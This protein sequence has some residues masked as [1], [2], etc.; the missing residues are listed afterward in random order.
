[1]GLMTTFAVACSHV[2]AVW[3]V[4][5]GT[6]WNF[7]V[8][9]VAEAACKSRVLAFDLFQLDNLLC[10]AGKALVS[11]VIGKLDD[12]RCMRIVM[13][14]QATG[15]IVVRFA[16]MTLATDRNNLFDGWRVAC[17]TILTANLGF[18]SAAI[19]GNSF[20]RCRVAFDAISITE[21]RLW[22]GR[23]GAQHGH[24]HQQR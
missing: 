15:Q 11:N 16:G 13:A 8:S 20:R 4:T 19:G 23:P 18:V 21:R 1:M 22:I 3:F 10:M 17:V 7:A 2:G 6:K 12:F 14:T 24:P 9:I 5:L